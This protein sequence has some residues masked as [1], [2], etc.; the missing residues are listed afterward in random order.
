MSR[1][2]EE[3]KYCG[4]NFILLLFCYLTFYKPENE[5]REFF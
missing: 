5:S 2:L 1:L 3:L 4:F